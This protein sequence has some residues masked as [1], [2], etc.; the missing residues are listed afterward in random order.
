M[1]EA[2]PSGGCARGSERGPA[3]HPPRALRAQEAPR[4]WTPEERWNPGSGY[5][6]AH[7]ANRE[8]AGR[9]AEVRPCREPTNAK[10][11]LPTED[12][13]LGDGH[14]EERGQE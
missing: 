14:L 10:E 2:R 7:S 6:E 13:H 1:G 3:A 5:V 4:G 8:E 9:G 11:T 12:G